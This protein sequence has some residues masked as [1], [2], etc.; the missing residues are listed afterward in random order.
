MDDTRLVMCWSRC[1]WVVA[2]GSPNTFD[3]FRDKACVF[4]KSS[5]CIAREAPSYKCE[6]SPWLPAPC[7]GGWGVGVGRQFH[8]S[9]STVEPPFPSPTHQATCAPPSLGVGWLGQESVHSPGAVT[10]SS[11]GLR[12]RGMCTKLPLPLLGILMGAFE[13]S[14]SQ[15]IAGLSHLSSFPGTGVTPICAQSLGVAG[16]PETPSRS[17]WPPLAP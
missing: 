13:T 3:L 6:A 12:G 7:W 8:L 16:P 4:F 5:L 15:A 2:P 14:P 1:S 10:D 9:L 17:Q 11:G